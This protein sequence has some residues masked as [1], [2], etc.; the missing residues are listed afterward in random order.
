MGRNHFRGRK[1][2]FSVTALKKCSRSGVI[3]ELLFVNSETHN[4]GLTKISQR[5][6]CKTTQPVRHGKDVEL[7]L[8]NLS[9]EFS[10][11]HVVVAES[12]FG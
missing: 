9:L 1:S 6:H 5:L 7:G 4:S 12:S 3:N 11:T 10:L 8:C 2:N